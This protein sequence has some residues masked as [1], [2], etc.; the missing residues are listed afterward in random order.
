MLLLRF[1]SR[2]PFFV[3]Y[4][5]SDF[6]YLFVFYVLRYRRKLVMKNL[7]N[8][9]P[10]KEKA[11]LEKIA[12]QFYRNFCDYGVETLKL[13]TI[14]EKELT[15]RFSFGDQE[16]IELHAQKNQ[17]V[18]Y[19]A[20]HQFNWEWG[21]V[22]ASTALPLTMDFVYQKVNSEF[23]NKLILDC[24]SRF[25][26]YPIERQKV[27][28][29]SMARRHILRGIATVTDQY[30]GHSGDKKYFHKFMNQD[31][32]FFYGVNQIAYLTQYPVFFFNI[33][34]L[35][36]GYYKGSFIQVGTPPY[37]KTDTRVI[38]EYINILE[39]CIK[40]N[41]ENYLWTHDRWK[42]R[43]LKQA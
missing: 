35:K 30:P 6:L 12:R 10:D 20:A 5:I 1:L 43:H 8:S 9:F 28:R 34:K 3:L 32:A 14:S 18:I 21:M 39:E 22:A 15:Q 11:S 4:R 27:A 23:F 17:S 25:G 37:D 29:E 33:E 42:K 31:T 24:R 26:A 36:R 16:L 2:L 41:P 7:G 13:L 40:Q 38:E 19:L